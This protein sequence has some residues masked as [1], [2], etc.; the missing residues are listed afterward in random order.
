MQVFT[1]AEIKYHFYFGSRFLCYPN[2]TAYN[3]SATCTDR[4]V[5]NIHVVYK[6]GV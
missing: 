2:Y 1:V 5:C 3:T 4:Q 6:D